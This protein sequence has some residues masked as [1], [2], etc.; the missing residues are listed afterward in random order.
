MVVHVVPLKGNRRELFDGGLALVLFTKVGDPNPLGSELIRQIF[1]L[2]A[3]EARVAAQLA[4][5][6][7]LE[8]I[9]IAHRVG[10][11]TVRTQ[12]KSVLQKL[13]AHRQA[14]IAVR[15]GMAAVPSTLKDAADSD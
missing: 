6:R 7:S 10:L 13:G 8:Q 2:T 1:D 9:A 15:L 5:G 4:Q 14:E 12:T 3:A 11:S